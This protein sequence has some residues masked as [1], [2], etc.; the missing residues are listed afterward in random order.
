MNLKI[1]KVMKVK[2]IK[3]FV[4]VM[5]KRGRSAETLRSYTVDLAAFQQ[6][7]ADMYNAPFFVDAL[8]TKELEAYQDY[9]VEDRQLAP[10]TVNRYMNS[11]RVFLNYCVR[12]GLVTVNVAQGIE[13]VK[14]VTKE[15]EYLTEEEVEE[16]L[17]EIKHPIVNCAV[18]VMA[19]SGLRISECL[20][21]LMTDV[22]LDKGTIFV[23][24]GKGGKSRT[25]PIASVLRPALKTYLQ[26][27]RPATSSLYFFAT[28]RTGKLSPQYVNQHLKEATESL[29]W[30]KRVSA[31]TLRHSFA[32]NLVHKDVNIVNV[33]KLLGHASLKTTSIYTHANLEQLEQAVDQLGGGE[34]HG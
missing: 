26:E 30:N 21:L 28:E 7:Y 18:R 27:D 6:Y 19:F 20:N 9:L 14:N 25:I 4:E 15:R 17:D 24:E 1:G 16:L 13:P 23:H 8:T 11:I 2:M 31:H 12:E 3:E 34:Q 32:S 29:K 5:K 22:D 33:S 10:A